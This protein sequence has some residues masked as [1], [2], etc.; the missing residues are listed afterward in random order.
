ML[1]GVVASALSYAHG[2][3][4]VHRDV[5]AGRRPARGGNGRALVT[6]F[7]IARGGADPGQVTDPGEDH[8]HGAVD[9]SQQAAGEPIYGQH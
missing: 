9:E 2:R 5:R 7:G 3:G 1:R 8:G 4:I 6:D